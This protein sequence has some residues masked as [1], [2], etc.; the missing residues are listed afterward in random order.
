MQEFPINMI[1]ISWVQR[2]TIVFSRVIVYQRNCVENTLQA[3]ND[4]S[5]YIQI[6]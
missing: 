4:P 5:Y 6:L 1:R 2:A 3:V